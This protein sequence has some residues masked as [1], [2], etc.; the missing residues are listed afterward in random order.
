MCTN[1]ANALDSLGVIGL[2]VAI[3]AF[4]LL[5]LDAFGMAELFAALAAASAERW[6]EFAPVG[7][8]SLVIG[9]HL[10]TALACHMFAASHAIGD[11]P[12]AAARLR[13]TAAWIIVASIA[14]L[15][16]R[17]VAIRAAAPAATALPALSYPLV[18]PGMLWS[19]VVLVVSRAGRLDAR[20]AH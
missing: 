13:F 2:S 6:R 20:A 17:V 15:A 18:A 16:I 1:R 8:A 5:G 12:R 7:I 4:V 10:A 11:R 19:V 3:L 9:G 14:W